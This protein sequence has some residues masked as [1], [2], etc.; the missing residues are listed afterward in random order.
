MRDLVSIYNSHTVS[1]ITTLST[2]KSLFFISMLS[3]IPLVASLSMAL[4]DDEKIHQEASRFRYPWL[5]MTL[6][7]LATV[8]QK[9]ETSDMYNCTLDC[10]SQ[11]NI[12]FVPH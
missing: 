12:I 9:T 10:K 1:V 8:C 11:F 5:N 4:E 3:V 6:S 7:N 2:M